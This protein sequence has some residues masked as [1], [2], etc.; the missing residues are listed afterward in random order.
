MK[1]ATSG[2]SQARPVRPSCAGGAGHQVDE[3]GQA[4]MCMSL[5][6]SAPVR[7]GWQAIM[8]W[9]GGAP[10]RRGRSGRHVHELEG[11][12]LVRRG[13]QATMCWEAG[14]QAHEAGQAIMCIDYID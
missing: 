3:A 14:R 9:R 1:S 8:C 13:W 10:G 12:V 2:A 5:G 7:R 6:G 11:S 4:V